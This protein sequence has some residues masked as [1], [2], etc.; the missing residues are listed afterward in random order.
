M[1]SLDQPLLVSWAFKLK[2]KFW[3]AYEI[4]FNHKGIL[5]DGFHDWKYGDRFWYENNDPLT[6]FKLNQLSEIKKTSLA[7]LVCDN[8]DIDF[9]QRNPLLEAN[10][11]YNELVDCKDLPFVDLAAFKDGYNYY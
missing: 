4:Y 7:R 10:E 1:A 11:G 2:K 6:G 8:S 5:G 9:I 3:F